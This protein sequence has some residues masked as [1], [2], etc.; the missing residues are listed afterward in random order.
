MKL[1]EILKK[2]K[3]KCA[4]LNELR[5]SKKNMKCI[6]IKNKKF[7][8]ECKCLSNKFNKEMQRE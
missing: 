2:I 3:N 8:K 1:I 7:N 5:L 4:M 6:K